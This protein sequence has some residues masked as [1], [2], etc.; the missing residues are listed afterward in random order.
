MATATAPTYADSLE[1]LT[2]ASVALTTHV[3]EEVAGSELTLLGWRVLVVVGEAS[4]GIRLSE[5]AERLRISR[6]SATKL[7]QRLQRRGYIEASRDRADA[8]GRR[9]QLTAPGSDLRE[10]V[11]R[12][13]RELLLEAVAA[14]LPADLETGLRVIADRL[15]RFV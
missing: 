11:L 12:R 10:T 9:L 13:R 4:D 15:A 6:P 5:L 3:L 2:F 14:E 1:R 8:R 7:I